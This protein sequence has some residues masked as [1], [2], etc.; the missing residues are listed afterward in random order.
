MIRAL[1][2]GWWRT[3]TAFRLAAR[4]LRRDPRQGVLV[5][6]LVALPVAAMVLVGTAVASQK[7]TAGERVAAELGSAEAWVRVGDPFGCSVVQSPTEPYAYQWATPD[8]GVVSIGCAEATSER[9]EAVTLEAVRSLLPADGE[10]IE[11]TRGTVVALTEDGIVVADAV[12]DA[13]WNPALRGPFEVREGEAPTAPDEVMVS[14]AFLDALGVAVGDEFSVEGV[15]GSFLITG[16]V[17]PRVDWGDVVVYA[18]PG[19]LGSSGDVE[20]AV[21]YLVGRSLTWDEIQDLNAHGLIVYSRTVAE[22]PPAHDPV[23]AYRGSQ[24]VDPGVVAAAGV[25]VFAVLLLAGAGFAVTFRRQRRT[26]AVLAATGAERGSLIGVGVARGAWLGLAGGVAGSVVG[27]VA[28]SAWFVTMTRWGSPDDQ[29][30][31]WGYH[32]VPTLILGAIVYGLVVGS[33]AAV[34]PA[35]AAARLDVVAAMRGT[36]R[37]ARARAWPVVLGAVFVAA[38]VVV[39]VVAARDH[40]TA[41]DL[42]GPEAYEV[43]QRA[44]TLLVVG[45]IMAFLGACAFTAPVLRVLALL[46][47][48]WPVGLRL[49]ARDLAR[50]G[51]RTV[52]IMAAIGIT[53]AIASTILLTVD[54]DQRIAE[55]TWHT[56]VPVGAGY[57]SLSGFSESGDGD[58]LER[59]LREAANRVV[60]GADV[61]VIWG[62]AEPFDTSAATA[63]PSFL[64]PSENLCPWGEGLSERERA[65]DPRCIGPDADVGSFVFDTAV[66]DE[67]DL[68]FLLGGEPSTEVRDALAQGEVV[69]FTEKLIRDGDVEIGL[70]DYSVGNYAG[71]GEAPARTMRLPAVFAGGAPAWWQYEAIMSPEVAASVGW[72]VAPG[73]FLVNPP[74][75]ITANQQAQLNVALRQL[76]GGAGYVR[77]G[78]GVMPLVSPLFLGVIVGCVLALVAGCTGIALGLARVDARRDDFTLASLGASPRLTRVVAAWQGAILVSVAT[79]IGIACGLAWMWVD[80]HRIVEGAP[81]PPW[82]SI[83]LAC[84][85]VPIL[86]AVAAA[87]FTRVP[88]VTHDRF[89]S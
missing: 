11:V 39:L 44:S 30:N 34:V 21:W 81:A 13:V 32:V 5:A 22:N 35:I 2:R 15:E 17:S 88:R 14:P 70:W 68:A 36:Q 9:P 50:H 72:T 8:A 27:L 10:Y 63:I 41:L 75:P 28:A 69:V 31:T 84:I 24:A 4:D 33:L 46:A 26:M 45:L 37:P 65:A 64:V 43:S 71:E 78:R 74:E 18:N 12:E 67:A 61:G 60:P 42:S 3:R 66:G 6:A 57:A 19:M 23:M 29:N 25:G 85:G 82:L 47:E 73:Y 1:I 16:V 62:W 83:A 7:P 77:V 56:F 59:D 55:R 79:F 58:R 54:R 51:G 20:S 80:A 52:P 53:V 87:L 40:A 49:A 86:V 89:P 48:R 76:T 38:G